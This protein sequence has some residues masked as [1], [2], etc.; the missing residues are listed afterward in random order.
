VLRPDHYACKIASIILSGKLRQNAAVGE[1]LSFSAVDVWM[2]LL[3]SIE[4]VNEGVICR[5]VHVIHSYCV[6]PA[7]VVPQQ[8]FGVSYFDVLTL[9]IIGV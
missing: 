3:I 7:F 6:L 5:V 9:E 2:N 4:N 8:T 1:L